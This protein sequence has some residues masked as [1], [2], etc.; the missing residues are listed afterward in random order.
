M[1]LILH[2]LSLLA[3]VTTILSFTSPL[4]HGQSATVSVS[5]V[6]PNGAGSLKPLTAQSIPFQINWAGMPAGQNIAID[7]YCEVKNLSSGA[8]SAPVQ[9]VTIYTGGKISGWS[10]CA[11]NNTILITPQ[12]KV[13]DKGSVT[14]SA[15]QR[16]VGDKRSVTVNGSSPAPRNP[17]AT[18]SASPAPSY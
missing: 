5:N 7:V 1:K 16:K 9:L 11:F 15:S 3:V 6:G 18:A 10:R 13:G 8:S 4:A 17:Q 14:V 2:H 12:G